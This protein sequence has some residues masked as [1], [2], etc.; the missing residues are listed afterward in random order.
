AWCGSSSRAAE[1][2]RRWA[3]HRGVRFGATS[4][5]EGP[6]VNT[7]ATAT[8]N[9]AAATATESPIAARLDDLREMAADDAVGAQIATWAWIQ[10]LAKPRP[11][12]R[13]RN[14]P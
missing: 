1:H 7:T 3:G 2:I 11:G 4:I 14:P 10:E 8:S 9:G 13:L 12:G 6:I 5:E